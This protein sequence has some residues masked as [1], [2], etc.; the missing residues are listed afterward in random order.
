MKSDE[1]YPL[2]VSFLESKIE[3]GKLS[4]GKFSLL[5]IS[6]LSFIEFKDKLL[7]DEL[8]YQKVIKFHK[9]EQRDK[10]IDDIFDD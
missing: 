4:K 9:S 6:Q 5:K 7:S 2:Y 1:H 10:K 8:F 3:N